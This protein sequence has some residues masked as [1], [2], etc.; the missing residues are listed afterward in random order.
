MEREIRAAG[1]PF[2]DGRVPE[3][4]PTLYL[5]PMGFRALKAN[6]STTLIANKAAICLASRGAKYLT[7]LDSF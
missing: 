1:G 6:P 7:I 2:L 3:E 5:M 4:A